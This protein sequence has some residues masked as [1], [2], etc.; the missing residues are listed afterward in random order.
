M[1]ARGLI[2]AAD[3]NVSVRV[4]EDRLVVTPT[5]ARKGF[6]QPIDLV[7]TDLSGVPVSEERGRPSTELAMHTTIYAVREDVR[8]VVH[9]HPPAAVAHSVAGVSLADP[10]MPEVYCELGEVWT[11]PYTT[12]GTEEVSAAIRAAIDGRAAL[13]MARHGSITVGPNLARAYD[14][15]EILEHTARIS[16]MA[17]TLS[18][19]VVGLDPSAL[20][21]LTPSRG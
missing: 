7:V 1:H 15:L 9:A 10:L 20:A 8:A 6:L 19:N 3:G 13:I 12:P 4:G 21:K 14:R 18:P 16:W 2:A 5:G 17:R 11:V